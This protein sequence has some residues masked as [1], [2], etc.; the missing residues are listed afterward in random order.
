MAPIHILAFQHAKTEWILD[1]SKEIKNLVEL[2]RMEKGC[3]FYRV[4]V[5]KNR[6]NIFIFDEKWHSQEALDDHFQS[7]FFQTFWKARMHYLEKDV[8]L[9]F[10]S[11]FS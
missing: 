9:Y 4:Y 10:L 3:L 5:E 8:E 2:S 6:Q 1:L 11:D 7:P